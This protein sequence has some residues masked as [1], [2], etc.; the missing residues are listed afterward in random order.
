L[1]ITVTVTVYDFNR[2]RVRV[3]GGGGRHFENMHGLILWGKL[4]LKKTLSV[5]LLFSA[6]WGVIYLGLNILRCWGVLNKSRLGLDSPRIHASAQHV[7]CVVNY[8]IMN[9]SRIPG[10]RNCQIE[11]AVWNW[12]GF[13]TV[14]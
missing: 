11:T 5:E 4:K 12:T 1:T 6:Q 2:V 10:H 14:L 3:V 9:Y 13:F 8:S 7:E